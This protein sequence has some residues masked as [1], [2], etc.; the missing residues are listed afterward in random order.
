LGYTQ[1]F[2]NIFGS[3]VKYSKWKFAI[4]DDVNLKLAGRFSY[5][6]TIGGFLNRDSVNIPDYTHFNGNLL[7]IAAPYLSSFQLAPYYKYS[8][9]NQ[10]YTTLHVEHH[11]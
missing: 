7:R 6:I 9:T 2:Q 1:A 5:T 11:F 10:F 3:D 4:N 8:N